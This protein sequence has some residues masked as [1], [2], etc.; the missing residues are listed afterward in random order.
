M[1]TYLEQIFMIDGDL[2]FVIELR[3]SRD[4]LAQ[5]FL[6]FL[7]MCQCLDRCLKHIPAAARV[8]KGVKFE[9]LRIYGF[10]LI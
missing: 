3:P 5:L 8:N 4:N 2:F 1:I 7:C 10:S 9:E 6:E